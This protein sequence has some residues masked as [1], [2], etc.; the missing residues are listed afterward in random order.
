[1]LI[2]SPFRFCCPGS[3]HITPHQANP[4]PASLVTSARVIKRTNHIVQTKFLPPSLLKPSFQSLESV[5]DS[6]HR[7]QS[8]ISKIL[9]TLQLPCEIVGFNNVE[10]TLDAGALLNASTIH[11]HKLQATKN[12]CVYQ[13]TFACLCSSSLLSFN[14]VCI[15]S[16]SLRVAFL[17]WM[18]SINYWCA[19]CVWS[20]FL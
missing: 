2:L 9:N 19:T 20:N 16:L 1:M 10:T 11:A 6:D 14:I 3:G 18:S 13:H 4:A 7:R 17:S 8:V 12:K 15:S 5:R